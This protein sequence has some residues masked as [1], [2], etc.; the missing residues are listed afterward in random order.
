MTTEQNGAD[1]APWPKHPDGTNKTLGE[2]SKEER[3]QQVAKSVERVAAEFAG[4]S[5]PTNNA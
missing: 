4:K 3:R 1:S 2:M 5:K